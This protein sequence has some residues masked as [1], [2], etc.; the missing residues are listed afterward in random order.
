M[1]AEAK[2]VLAIDVGNSRV[3]LGWAPDEEVRDVQR[4]A[5]ADLADAIGDALQ[6]LWAKM[7]SPGVVVASSV[8]SA[9]S[10]MISRA[11]ADR[12]GRDLLLI[13]RDVPLPIETAL[14]EPQHVGTDRLCAAAMAYHRV[15]QACVVA[16]FGTAVTIDC[17]DGE[18]VFLGGAILPGLN[19][20]AEALARSTALPK[21]ALRRPDWVFGRDT[22]QAIIGGLIYGARGA[23]REMVELYATELK[24]WPQLIL[25]G[26]DA[27]LV[28]DGCDFVDAVVADL[29]LMGVALACRLA[30]PGGS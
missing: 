24:L 15:G 7:P 26:G 2:P 19:T 8:N 17:V 10:D 27:E 16:D 20:G 29:T 12:L 6:G 21:V 30:P 4:V 25:T 13:G 18:G 28:A 23:L 22:P 11:A 5:A 3:S 1:T 14:D 9:T